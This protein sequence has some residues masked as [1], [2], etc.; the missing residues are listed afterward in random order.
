VLNP[1]RAIRSTGRGR[2]R[3]GAFHGGG[4]M[5]IALLLGSCTLTSVREAPVIDRTN[6]RP[7]GD[8]TAPAP[9]GAA[10][11]APLPAPPGPAGAA[12]GR[13][14]RDGLY[15][16]QRGDTLY[17]IALAFQ[18]DWRDIARWSGVEDNALIR[19]GQALRVKPPVPA[20]TAAQAA[21]DA[22]GGISTVPILPGAVADSRPLAAPGSGA[23]PPVAAPGASAAPPTVPARSDAAGAGS[24][25]AD[26]AARPRAETTEV[27]KEPASAWSWPAAGRLLDR[28]EDPRNKGID[29]AGAEGDAV[30]AAND[31]DVVYNGSGLRGYGNLVIIKHTDDYIS[32]YAHNREIVVKQGQSVKRGQR[33]ATMGRTDAEAPKL[34]FE[35]RRQGKPV[36]PLKYLPAR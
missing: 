32:A 5:V 29:I 16:V 1:A 9:G 25:V 10:P 11:V 30:L 8:G 14:A 31:G 6:N 36:D 34:H 28:F 4:L 21:T 23:S 15:T 19:P 20:G 13:E 2:V 18:Q 26:A 3:S 35:I 12:G 24:Q 7:P 17:S 27:R 22:A 33:I